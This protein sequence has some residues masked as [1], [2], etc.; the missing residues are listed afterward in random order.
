MRE[1][2][3]GTPIRRLDAISKASG[4]QMY[5]SDYRFDGMLYS[6]MVRST[7]ARGRI[8]AITM[9]PLPDGYYFITHKD[10]P[11]G[12]VNELYMIKKD[13]RCF[14]KGDV[15][16]IGETIGLLVGPDRGVLLDLEHG[17]VIE[18]EEGVPSISIEEGLACK[19]GPFVGDKNLFCD[20]TIDKGNIDEVLAMR[21]TQAGRNM[22]IWRQMPRW[23]RK[24]VTSSLSTSAANVRSMCESRSQG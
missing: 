7:V 13:Y 2:P 8:T 16:Y 4:T 11:E 12:G 23:R 1:T 17:I 10:I 3:I 9:P 6:R 18:Y 14:A 19:G 5:L 24:R 21:S 15:R 22:S 20:F